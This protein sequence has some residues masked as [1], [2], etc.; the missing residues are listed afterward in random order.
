M[1]QQSQAQSQAQTQAQL[2]ALREQN[3]ILNQ[4]LASQAQ[5]H[6]QH[7]Q[8]LLPFHQSTPT[9]HPPQSTPSAPE[10]PTPVAPQSTPPG[11]SVSFNAEEMMQQMKNTVESSM[12]VFVDKNQERNKSHPP[13]PTQPPVPTSPL[14]PIHNPPSDDFPPPHQ[15]SHRRSRSHRH[16]SGPRTPDKRPISIPRSPHRPKSCRRAHRLSRPRPSSRRRR[17]TSRNASRRP[18]RAASITLRSA[19]PGRREVPHRGDDDH[20][21]QEPSHLPANLHPATWEHHPQPSSHNENPQSNDYHYDHHCSNKWKSWGQWKDYSKSSYTSHP[22]GWIDYTKPTFSDHSHYDAHSILLQSHHYN[23]PR[24]PPHRSG[25]VQSRGSTTVPPGRVAINLQDGSK[26]EWV[27]HIRH[28]L[29][30]PDRMRAANEL[31]AAE[32]PKPSTTIDQEEYEKAC[33]QLHQVDQRIPQ[34]WS[35]RRSNSFSAPTFSLTTIYPLAMSVN[36]QT[37]TGLHSSCLYQTPATSTCHLPSANSTITPGHCV[38]ERQSTLLSK[39][40]WK[41]RSDL[42]T[43]LITKTLSVVTYQPLGHSFLA[44]KY[45]T[46]TEQSHLGQNENSLTPSARK[47]RASR[48]SS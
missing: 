45:P 25:S 21:L 6:I 12:Q 5:S 26:E 37:P 28:A 2:A 16:R 24:R 42:Q 34:M 9:P 29:N 40:S 33:E 39:Y 8:Q 43:G 47:A 14:I 38:M 31:A 4:Q 27:R 3:S 1:N 48:T 17:S 7:L 15:R 32:R 41:A 30:H 46:V 22:S 44:E 18:S 35:R 23:R 19:S 11:S 36:F 20:P 13:L 10:P